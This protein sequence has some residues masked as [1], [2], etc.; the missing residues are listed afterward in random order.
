MAGRGVV[1]WDTV[2]RWLEDGTDSKG[3]GFESTC[4]C[5]DV[6]AVVFISHLSRFIHL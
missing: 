4:Y 2:A 5:F 1:M 3:P 6:W